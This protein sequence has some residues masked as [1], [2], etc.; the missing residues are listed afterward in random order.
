LESSIVKMKSGLNKVKV[1]TAMG[2]A[3]RRPWLKPLVITNKQRNG[4][5]LIELLV[6]IAIIAI[7]AAILLP[8]LNAAQERARAISCEN[9]HKQLILA[10]DMY[11]NENNDY[12][13]PNPALSIAQGAD[14]IGSTW[15]LGYQHCDPN[16]QDNTNISYLQTSLLAPYC[17]YAVKIYKCPDDTWKCTEGGAPMDRVR[18]VSMNTCIE[19]NY[20]LANGNGG[21]PKDEA[22]YP[23]TQNVKVYCYVKWTDIGPHT[24]GPNMSDM[25]V[26]TD[27]NPNTINNGNQSWFA[28]SSQ[29]S[30][31]PG[32][33]HNYGNNYS[34]AD[35]HVEYHKWA[36]RW[37]S[38]GGGSG[39]GLAGW[40][41]QGVNP[42]SGGPLWGSRVDFTWVTE[43]ATATHP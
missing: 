7:L 29:W 37:S 20:Y 4:F 13:C 28:S 11:P 3:L 24:P 34:F 36:T 43:H 22:Y 41:C 9:N 39:T 2:A 31:T 8:V 23:A 25:W 6:V 14:T 32:S 5:T 21:Y 17:S 18:S 19:G 12:L 1:T 30:D 42:P 35:G 40:L 10:W 27:E 15:V 26:M 33:Y 16:T 38:A